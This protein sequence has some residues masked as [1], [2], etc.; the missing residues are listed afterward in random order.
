MATV[1][2]FL[3]DSELMLRVQEDVEG[4]ARALTTA[5]GGRPVQAHVRGKR[6]A[7]VREPG[8]DRLLV[9]G[10]RAHAGR[11]SWRTCA[12]SSARGPATLE[13]QRGRGAR[14]AGR[15][16]RARAP[17]G[18]RDVR[19]RCGDGRRRDAVPGADRARPRVRGGG[20][21]GRGRG[22]VGR[23]RRARQRPVP[24]LV[25]RMRRVPARPHRRTAARVRALPMYGFGA[26]GGDWGGFLSDVVRVP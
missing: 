16:R 23:A 17:G 25:R 1:I 7:R 20:G 15:R 5:A 6:R 26:V 13:W 4:V 18:R 2:R 14:P 3:G 21:R 19:P 10:R 11:S 24:G 9:L 22:A 12:R 8:R